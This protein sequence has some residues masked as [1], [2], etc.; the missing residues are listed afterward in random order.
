MTTTRNHGHRL[1]IYR[2]PRPTTLIQL[3]VIIQIRSYLEAICIND[4][5]DLYQNSQNS[6][7][8]I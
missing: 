8:T 4:R 2:S 5:I 1:M 7:L 3:Y 6:N